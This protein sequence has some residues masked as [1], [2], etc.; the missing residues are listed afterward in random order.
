MDDQSIKQALAVL[1]STIHTN[2]IKKGW[3][4][5]AELIDRSKINIPEKL[6]LIHAEVSEA[7]EALRK[8]ISQ[9]PI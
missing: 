4:P 2:G 5:H 6:A 8:P 9:Q 1:Q 7:L 3:W